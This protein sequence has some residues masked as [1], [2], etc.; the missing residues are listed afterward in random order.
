MGRIVFCSKCEN[1]T[2]VKD[3]QCP[4]D[5]QQETDYVLDNKGNWI[6]PECQNNR[7]K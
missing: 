4:N 5:I 7:R 6:C 3:A 1:E 2:Y